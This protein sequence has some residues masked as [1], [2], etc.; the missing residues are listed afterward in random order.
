MSSDM[1]LSNWQTEKLPLDVI[2]LIMKQVFLTTGRRCLC[3]RICVQEVRGEALTCVQLTC[4]RWHI[5]WY[6]FIMLLMRDDTDPFC[7]H[8]D[9]CS[10]SYVAAAPALPIISL[11]LYP[12]ALNETSPG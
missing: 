8:P 6:R 3:G 11:L 10:A 4:D 2:A 1:I 12:G 5:A 9:V 7:A